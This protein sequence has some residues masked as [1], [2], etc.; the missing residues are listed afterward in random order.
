MESR[1]SH[2]AHV[3]FQPNVEKIDFKTGTTT[4]PTSATRAKVVAV[5]FTNDKVLYDLAIFADGGFYEMFPIRSV[6]SVFVCPLPP[7]VKKPESDLAEKATGILEEIRR[8]KND[9][10]ERGRTG[11]PFTMPP[12]PQWA[13]ETV[14]ESYPSFPPGTIIC[15]DVPLM[16]DRIHERKH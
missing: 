10:I 16:N 11:W 6:D 8:Q 13:P 1:F 12:T 14:K 7:P 15:L 2:G 4:D 3:L 5:S 9:E